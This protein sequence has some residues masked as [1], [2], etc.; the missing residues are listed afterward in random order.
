L[1]PLPQNVKPNGDYRK[2]KQGP[3]TSDRWEWICDVHAPLNGGMFAAT[4]N[5]GAHMPNA[6]SRY[7]YQRTI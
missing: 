3:I 7:F 5:L 6:C 1:Y 4:L 2:K